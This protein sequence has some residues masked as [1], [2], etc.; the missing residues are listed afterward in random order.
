[1][2]HDKKSKIGILSTS[3]VTLSY[4]ALTPILGQISKNFSGISDALAQMVFTLPSLMMLVFAVFAG[5]LTQ[6][7]YKRTLIL[8]GLLV[9]LCG[10]IFPFFF[11]TAI[12]QLLFG[13]AL[14]G[15]GTSFVSVIGNALI[16]DCFSGKERG[17]LMGLN[18]SFVGI[19]GLISSFGGGQ[20]ASTHWYNA[21]LTFLI[22]V[23]IFI[24]AYFFLPQGQLPQKNVR[25]KAK[26]QF[27]PSACI[28]FLGIIGFLYFVFQ[29][30]YNTNSALLITN[31]GL[32]GSSV[33]SLVTMLNAVGG[34]TGGLC[35]GKFYATVR[36][37]VESFAM[38]IA[39]IGFFLSFACSNLPAILIGGFLVGAAF[40]IFNAAGTLL[41]SQYVP[42]EQNAFTAAIYL[43]VINLGAAI[44]PYI[45]NTL[46]SVAA[47]G[48]AVRFLT[49]GIMIGICSIVSFF[50]WNTFQKRTL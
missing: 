32:G 1:M 14:M 21:Y 49:C 19:G 3:I 15:I 23:P 48:P 9:F 13:S 18:A 11:H 34:I 7:F 39:A 45:V 46:A 29:N 42:I 33:A 10:G 47:P 28:Y 12:W 35:F 36:K 16:C 31:L 2:N 20:L 8:F 43:A 5:K 41:I 44:S 26:V 6:Y 17:S 27:K 25:Q 22:L 37:Q 4:M 38:L 30:A 24:I 40:A 50:F